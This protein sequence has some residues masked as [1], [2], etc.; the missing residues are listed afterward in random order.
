MK[1]DAQKFYY[2]T[3]DD[4]L[5]TYSRHKYYYGQVHL[6]EEDYAHLWD[7]GPGF[8][9]A[10][11]VEI[12]TGKAAGDFIWNSHSLLIVSQRVLDVWEGS[13]RIETYDVTVSGIKTDYRYKGVICM[14][15]AGGFDP[16]RS[17]ARYLQLDKK[18]PPSLMGMEGFY[19]DHST[20]DGSELFI[21]PDFPRYYIATASLMSRMKKARLTNIDFLPL[22]MLRF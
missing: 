15:R 3:T 22:E 18:G 4:L 14:G 8:K 1:T 20:W 21:L 5:K 6:E 9:N 11:N 10:V 7:A 16:V 2:L 12:D 17:K 19:F 13:V